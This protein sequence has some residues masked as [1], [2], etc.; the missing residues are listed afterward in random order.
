MGKVSLVSP[1]LTHFEVIKNPNLKRNRNMK[2]LHAFTSTHKLII[3]IP[4]AAE[5]PGAALADTCRTDAAPPP[6]TELC[7][8]KSRRCSASSRRRLCRAPPPPARPGTKRE[9]GR[10]MEAA[11]LLGGSGAKYETADTRNQIRS[12]AS[13]RTQVMT[14]CRHLPE[15]EAALVRAAPPSASVRYGIA[16][17]MQHI[18]GDGILV[19]LQ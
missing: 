3:L 9:H 19:L 12:A 14:S 13:A 4:A 7:G 6:R 2:A 11:R 16:F 8:F 15:E 17:S 1:N 5:A 18:T 10:G